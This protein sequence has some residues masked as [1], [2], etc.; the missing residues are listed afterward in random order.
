MVKILKFLKK[1]YHL[2]VDKIFC[3]SGSMLEHCEAFKLLCLDEDWTWTKQNFIE[4]FINKEFDHLEN[5]LKDISVSNNDILTCRNKYAVFLISLANVIS[6]MCP[7][8][9]YAWQ[10]LSQIENK[11]ESLD[12]G[13]CSL[14]IYVTQFYLCILKAI[15]YKT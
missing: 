14:D 3:L 13:E 12:T 7:D 2:F 1:I 10:I 15:I 5:I 4:K 8:Q 11:L 6:V 9:E